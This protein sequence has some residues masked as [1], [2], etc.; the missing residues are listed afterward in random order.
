MIFNR[1]LRNLAKPGKNLSER[2]IK[3]GFWIFSVRIVQQLFGFVRIIIL[4]RV[5]A[6]HDFGLMGIAL[7]MLTILDT[8]TQTGLHQALIQKKDDIKI[9]LDTVWTYLILRGVVLFAILYLI[10]PYV[11]TFFNTPEAKLMVQVIGFAILL[12]AFTNIGTIYFQKELEFNKLFFY[13]IS[14]TLS[15]FIVTVSLVFI[16]KNVWALVFGLIAS[17]LTGCI[18]SYIIHPFS[19]RLSFDLRKVKGLFG[20]GKWVWSSAVLSFFIL[21]GDSMFVGKFLGAAALGFY[22]MAYKISNLPATEISHMIAQATFPAYSKLQDDIYR[23]R[24]A[25]L[26]VLQLTAF[27]SFPMA[28]LIFILAPD[29]TK[30]FLGEKWMPMVPAIQILVFAGLIRSIAA[31][32][33]YIFYAV[34]KPKINTVWQ[35]VQLSV[36]AALIYPFSVKWGITGVSMVVFFSMFVSG[37]GFCFK[38]IKITKCGVKNFVN[39]IIYPLICGIAIVLL[40]LGLKTIMSIGLL[41]F[42]IFAC[43]GVLAYLIV[44]YLLDKLFNYKK[45]QTLIKESILSFRGI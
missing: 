19:P 35:I 22:Q 21:Q 43:A 29:F 15:D 11:A 8:F 28:G 44:I 40:I 30:I 4:A 5:L 25:Y 31:T 36:L 13:Q 42:I 39:T 17:N 1:V 27:L 26:K 7:L 6:P 33:G 24:E 2:T 32:T 3:S 14:I 20:F 12:Q 38:A 41:E 18:V 23:L 9:Y 45:I 37:I 34:G 10:A 16:L